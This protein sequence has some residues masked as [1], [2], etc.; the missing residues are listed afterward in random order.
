MISRASW[1][2]MLPSLLKYKL[3]VFVMRYKRWVWSNFIME[4]AAM[5]ASIGWI[6]LPTK[7]LVVFFVLFCFKAVCPSRFTLPV[8]L[9]ETYF[10]SSDTSFCVQTGCI[11][12]GAL[13]ESLLGDWINSWYLLG[14]AKWCIRRG[15]KNKAKPLSSLSWFFLQALYNGSSIGSIQVVSSSLMGQANLLSRVLFHCDPPWRHWLFP[16]DLNWLPNLPW[17]CLPI[18]GKSERKRLFRETAQS[19]EW[20]FPFPGT[21]PWHSTLQ[22]LVPGRMFL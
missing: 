14:C 19:C 7:H 6:S 22:L 21:Q 10:T 13:T 2:R 9:L 5:V 18:R 15:K 17:R 3:D 16:V 4:T 11:M 8:L 1:L 12:P 20:R